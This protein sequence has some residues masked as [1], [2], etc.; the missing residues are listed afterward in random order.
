VLSGADALVLLDVYA[1]GEDPIAG[2][3]GRT[4]ARAI[5]TRG[6]VDPV[7]VERIDDLPDV[8][9][10]VL[11]DGDIVLTMGAGDIGACARSLPERLRVGPSLK[12]HS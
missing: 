7:F 3:D 8:L 12:V 5:R 1:A 2:A 6:A 9:V 11:A 4:M 10:G